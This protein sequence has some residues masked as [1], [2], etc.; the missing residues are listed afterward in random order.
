M[1]RWQTR[2]DTD[3]EGF[4]ANREAMAALLQE[5]EVQLELAR[6]GGGERS[7]ARHR[8]RGK[9]LVRER[10]E[11]LLDPDSPFLELSPLAGY[12]TNY[13]VGGGL[14][15]GI[16]VVSGVEC[17]IA[18]NDPTVL[19][20]AI[21]PVSMKK[22][23]RALEIS[24]L[25]RLPYVQFVESAGADLR[26]GE[27]S[28]EA[29]MQR[30]LGHFAESG[31]F[32]HDITALS[33][34]R[35]PTVS[36]VFGSSTAGGAYQPGMSDYNIFIRGRSKVF[37]GGPPLVKMAT[38]EDSS[39]EE[40]GGAEMHATM[41]GLADYLAEDELDALRI[42][43]SV[44]AHLNW[45]KLGPGPTLPADEP[46]YPTEELLGL[47]PVDLRTPIDIRE[48][49]ARVVDGS[50][51]E[52]FKPLY[53]RTLVT[54]WASVHGFPV[55]I[56]GNNGVLFS[57]ESQKATQFI[58]LCNQIDVPIIFLQNITGY[59][60]GKVYE[61]G[62]IVKDGSKM[63]NAV[64]NS[65]VPHLTVIIGASYGAGNYGMGG[66]AYDTRFVFTWPTAKIAVMGPKQLAGVM[67]IVRRGSAA[68]AG[69]PFD[70]EE[71]A[72]ITAAVEDRSEKES[73]ALYATGRVAD[74][75]IIDPRDTRTVLGIAL[76]ACHN[77]EVK[78][79]EGYGVFRM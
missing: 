46:L 79:A 57:E 28:A 70:E 54:G 9:L 73:L 71:D 27:D 50:R 21:T 43:R 78:G 19:G 6:A 14:V 4:Q 53:G 11:L 31:R 42:T 45:R 76:S 49:I 60:V 39:D 20:G 1:E 55:G 59:M 2:I 66:R 12:C 68:A 61:Q 24:R 40:L 75:G 34:A 44:I 69:R 10:I 67:S 62:G 72:R 41:S 35:I 32:F 58:Q 74:D 22:T 29:E 56:L 47:L 77:A 51:F 36:L 38:G 15:T 18:A 3:S 37:L 5:I 64:S 65:T 63:I 16:G 8:Q 33:A 26:R 13:T 17:I 23:D 48:V 7:V 30:Q 25:N 52:E